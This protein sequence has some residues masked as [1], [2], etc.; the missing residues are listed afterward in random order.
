[1]SKVEHNKS[2]FYSKEHINRLEE[3]QKKLAEKV[4][5]TPLDESTINLIAGV[6]V[7]YINGFSIGVVVLLNNRLEVL[8]VISCIQKTSF[9]Y[10]PGFLAFRE[11]PVILRAFKELRKDN[12]I[13]D[14][15]L[16]D[17]HGIAHPR[18]LGIASHA[19]VLL[20][21]PT[22]GVAKSKLYGFCDIPTQPG[23]ATYVTD[24]SGNIIGYCY[25]SKPKVKPI[26]ISPGHLC[27]IESSL[28][29]VKS[30]TKH[31]RLPEPTRIAHLYSQRIKKELRSKINI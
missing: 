30:V 2:N 26:F 22:I 18:K 31:Y 11:V 23:E 25:L 1:M 27:D 28:R 6:D 24:K 13:P 17:G 12:F 21:I 7:S 8:K 20:D 15:V 16:F 5:L 10:I 19:G 3:V 14:V 29:F 9:P 4:I